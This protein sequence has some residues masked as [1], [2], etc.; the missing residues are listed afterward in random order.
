MNNLYYGNNLEVLRLYIKEE[1]VDLVYLDPPFKSNQDYNVLFMEKDG[2]LSKSQMQA[3]EDTWTWDQEAEHAYQEVVERGGKPSTVMQAFHTFLGPTDMLAYLAMMAPRL[4]ELHRVLKGTGSIYLHCDP[5]ASHYLKLLMD[6]IFGPEQFRN[7]VI[8]RRTGSHNSPRR[9]GPIHDSILFYS[10]TDDYYF[11]RVFRPYLNGHVE[12]Y[13]RQHDPDRGRYW[14]NALTGPG[15]RSGYSGKPWKNYDPTAVGRHWAIPGKITEELGIEDDDLTSQQKLDAIDEAG[16]VDFPAEGS[17]AMPTYRQYLK[18]S[19]GMPLQDLWTYQ[20]H[21]RG[22]LYE[23]EEGIDEDVRWLVAQGD[24]ERLGYQTQKPKGLLERIIKSSCPDDGVVL[25]PFCGCGTTIEASETL[26]RT[27]IGIDITQAAIVVIKQRLLTAFPDGLQYQVVGEPT[28]LPDAEA[29]AQQ[30]AYQFQW[31]ALGLVN[32]RP[33]EKK[34]G[35]D[36]GIDGRLYFHDE[37]DRT[38]TKQIILSVKSGKMQLSYVRDLRGVIDREGAD[39]GALICLDQPTKQMRTE[40]V[41]AGFYKSSWGD[42]PRIQILTIK[43]LLKGKGIDYPHPGVNVTFKRAQRAQAPP[44]KQMAFAAPASVAE[45]F[46][47][48]DHPLE[49]AKPVAKARPAPKSRKKLK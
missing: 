43:D 8:W 17:H 10:K 24:T 31:W 33:T 18:D 3:F 28:S 13:F 29:L 1:T 4:M 32:A 44:A 37:E 16:F 23:S 40:A 26:G 34:K 7:E 19:P 6:A 35:A 49:E 25:D 48:S 41:S 46:E 9:Y 39:I 14:T 22:V 11:K 2:S 47:E 5:A 12:S 21:T 42:H 30:D 27:W 45:P 20:P 36:K 38:K 15:T